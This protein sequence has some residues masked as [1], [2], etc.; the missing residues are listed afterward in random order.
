MFNFPSQTNQLED[1]FSY[2]KK[3]ADG[4]KYVG[5]FCPSSTSPQI[6]LSKVIAS[7]C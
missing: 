4:R 5:I 2:E 1:S 3:D 6:T 7:L